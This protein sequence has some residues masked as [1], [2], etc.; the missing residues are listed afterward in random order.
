MDKIYEFKRYILKYQLG[1]TLDNVSFKCLTSLGVGGTCR[2][3]YIPDDIETLTLSVKYLINQKI[4]YFI[5]GAGTNLLVNDKD[6]NIVVISLKKIK[7]YYLLEEDNEYKYIY[8]ESGL[9][10]MILSKYLM[11]KEISGAEFLSVIPGTIGGLIYMN[12]GAYKKCMSDIIYSVTYINEV[13]NIITKINCDNCFDFKYRSSNFKKKNYIILSVI[14][15]LPK[16]NND[17]EVSK[18]LV[19][20][21]I[22]RKKNTQPIGEKNAGSTFKNLDNMF[23]WEIIDK[24]GFRGYSVGDAVVSNKHANFIINRNNATF[25][26]MISLISKIKNDALI[27][28]NINLECEWE[29][30]D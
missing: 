8:A 17:I 28:Y 10:G 11:D 26:D 9:R 27:K 4:K 19:N 13:G 12:A 3:M 15:K 21:Y 1:L 16:L 6:Y 7:R 20:Q 25:N 30:L 5:I 14:I 23:T 2:L 22:T 24:L 29:I 18:S